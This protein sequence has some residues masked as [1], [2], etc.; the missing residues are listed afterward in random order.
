MGDYTKKNEVDLFALKRRIRHD[1][2][3]EQQQSKLQNN[4]KISFM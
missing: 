2:L 4:V 1:M 3:S